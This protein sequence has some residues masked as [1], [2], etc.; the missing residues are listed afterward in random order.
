MDWNEFLRETKENFDKFSKCS[1]ETF[2]GFGIMGKDAKKEGA[3]SE[4][5]KEFI[6]R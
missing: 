5:T 6:V 4:K 1:P 2:K 3:L